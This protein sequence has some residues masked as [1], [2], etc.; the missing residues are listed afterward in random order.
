MRRGAWKLVFGKEMWQEAQ[1]LG[2]IWLECH[3]IGE[4]TQHM[5]LITSPV[6]GEEDQDGC[7]QE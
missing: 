2:G 3:V 6:V 7:L 5:Y 4:P 1:G